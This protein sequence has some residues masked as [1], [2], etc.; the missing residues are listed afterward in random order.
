MSYVYLHQ[1]LSEKVQDL[2]FLRQTQLGIYNEDDYEAIHPDI[3]HQYKE[4]AL[5]RTHQHTDQTS[6]GH[7]S[8]GSEDDLVEPLIAKVVQDQGPNIRHELIP[9]ADHEV[10]LTTPELLALFSRFIDILRSN[11][12]LLRSIVDQAIVWDSVEVIWVWHRGQKE[13]VVSL[14][15]AVWEKRGLLWIAALHSLESLV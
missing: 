12:D 3:M 13:L 2:R 6:V 7:P 1:W 11:E 10:P 9:T 4:T 14:K 15:D 8:E 5:A